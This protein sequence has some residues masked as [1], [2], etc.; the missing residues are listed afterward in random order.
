MIG[1]AT[2]RSVVAIMGW[3]AGVACAIAA[4]VFHHRSRRV[5]AEYREHRE[6]LTQL[7]QAE[8]R[9]ASDLDELV[10]VKGDM[11]A[12]VA[13][14]LGSPLAAIRGFSDMLAT[15]ELTQAEQARALAMIEAETALLSALMTDLEVAASVDGKPFPVRPAPIELDIVLDEAVGFGRALPGE[16]TIESDIEP[17]L[18]AHADQERIGQ[19]LRNLVT[20]AAK[21]SD[22]GVPITVMA[23]RADD[24]IEVCVADR[25]I[26]VHPDDIDRIFE[27]YVRGRDQLT[28][29]AAGAGLGLY[30]ARRMV[31]APGSDLTVEPRPG[32]GSVFRF[33]LTAA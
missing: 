13:H 12:M 29:P 3:G 8:R 9:R 4:A 10:A 25:G 23:H 32:G 7:L 19:V 11:A 2:G 33:K 30:L 6:E 28:R 17:G 31:Q 5:A 20:N 14:E 26:G 24:A 18:R 22:P 27:K 15:G 1:A 21:Y 16:H